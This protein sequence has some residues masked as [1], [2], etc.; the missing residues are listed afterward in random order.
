MSKVLLALVTA[1]SL[2]VGLAHANLTRSEPGAGS[3]VAGSSVTEIELEFSEGLEV[4][5][6]TF[7]LLR[8]EHDFD[9][10]D[11]RFRLRLN[12][13]A[14][15]RFKE[16]LAA[17]GTG[18][19]YVSFTLDPASGRPNILKLKLEHALPPGSYALY[20]R[21]LSVDT[22]VVEDYLTFTIRP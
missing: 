5:F 2:G 18:P 22:H 13:L 8:L 17:A 20:W 15:G 16:A 10:A 12:A 4:L 11:D 1:A 21:V 14:A 6:S 9:T 7:R 3:V 19:E